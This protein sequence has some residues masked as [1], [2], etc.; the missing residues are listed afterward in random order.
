MPACVQMLPV[1]RPQHRAAAG[2]QNQCGC[3]G[4]LV[5]HLGL[6]VSKALLALMLKILA[7]RAA[8]ALLNDQV[9]IR[10]SQA[11]PTRQLPPNGGFARA[12]QANKTDHQ[13]IITAWARKAC[14]PAAGL[15][16]EGSLCQ[17]LG[18]DEYQQFLLVGDARAALEQIAHQRQ[19]AEQGHFGLGV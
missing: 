2:R 11:Q 17:N 8:D 1:D 13:R 6:N 3:L 5:E 15:T 4:E 18:R 10:K 19:V 14:G 12:R 9:R 7:D 16:R